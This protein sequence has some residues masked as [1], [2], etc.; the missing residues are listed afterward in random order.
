MAGLRRVDSREAAARLREMGRERELAWHLGTLPSGAPC[1]ADVDDGAELLSRDEQVLDKDAGLGSRDFDPTSTLP[2]HARGLAD[3]SLGAMA[4]EQSPT[5]PAPEVPV[6]QDAGSGDVGNRDAGN[7]FDGA[8]ESQ[9]SSRSSSHQ[10]KFEPGLWIDDHSDA[11]IQIQRRASSGIS[12]VSVTMRDGSGLTRH[13]EQGTADDE[14]HEDPS[15]SEAVCGPFGE[16]S[17]GRRGAASDVHAS[18]TSEEPT[19]AAR[20]TDGDHTHDG[21]DAGKLVK[22][23]TLPAPTKPPCLMM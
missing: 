2:V 13:H 1:G 19:H 9:S 3:G 7:V 11:L 15:M 4:G 16:P 18:D 8:R 12:M 5:Q 21:D 17:A 22:P 10:E 6:G 23:N 14:H 20:D